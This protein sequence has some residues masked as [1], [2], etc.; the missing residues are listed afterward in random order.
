MENF[1]AIELT[2]LLSFS[3]IR[4]KLFHFRTSD[5]KEVDF[6]LERP[7]G[8][9]AGIEVKTADRVNATDFKGLRMLQEVVGDDFI[10]GIVFYN[11]KNV[12]SFGENLFAMTMGCSWG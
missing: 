8:T 2:K 5:G 3:N 9:L 1:V 4:A 12:V 6:V 7:N 11:G 10:S